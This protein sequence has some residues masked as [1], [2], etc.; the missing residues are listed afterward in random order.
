MSL[1]PKIAAS[2]PV[3]EP[4]EACTVVMPSIESSSSS[5]TVAAASSSSRLV[6]LGR[7]WAT[8]R[9]FWP[10]LPMKLVCRPVDRAP[11]PPST[12][13]ASSSVATGRL[14]VQRMTGR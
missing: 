12:S 11:V 9:V 8:V 5:T 2:V 13:T 3:P 7:V 6:P 4:I 10:E 14:S 1:P